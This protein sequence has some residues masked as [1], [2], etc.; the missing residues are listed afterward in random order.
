MDIIVGFEKVPVFRLLS[1]RKTTRKSFQRVKK[2]PTF[3]DCSVLAQVGQP[4]PKSFLVS[5]TC[6]QSDF[7]QA[8][9]VVQYFVYPGQRNRP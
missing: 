1:T 2:S 6:G 4:R 7:T 8:D 3:F 9:V 5:G